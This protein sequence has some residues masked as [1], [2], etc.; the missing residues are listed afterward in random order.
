MVSLIVS[1]L[2]VLSFSLTPATQNIERS[3]LQNN[4]RL[5]YNLFSADHPLNVSLPEPIYFSDF[6]SNQQ[7]FF[8]FKAIFSSY[9]TFEFYSER[10]ELTTEKDHYIYKARWSFQDKK[11]N[12]QYLF[13]IFFYLIKDPSPNNGPSK[14]LWTITE[15]KAKKV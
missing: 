2:T 1:A 7:A 5:L 14:S 11:N 10:Q 15:I 8:F 6:L 13:Y 9:S 12:D 3:F 4:P